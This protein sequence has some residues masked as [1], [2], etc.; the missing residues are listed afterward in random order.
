[1]V[2]SH[3]RRHRDS[4]LA[5][6]VALVLVVVERLGEAFRVLHDFLQC[7]V[8]VALAHIDRFAQDLVVRLVVL[9]RALHK[10]IVSRHAAVGN[11][12]KV[13]STT[14][15]IVQVPQRRDVEA[16]VGN[17]EPVVVPQSKPDLLVEIQREL[18]M[19]LARTNLTTS[20][21]LLQVLHW[22]IHTLAV[23][24]VRENSSEVCLLEAIRCAHQNL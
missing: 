17:R 2:D 6:E 20:V 3:L 24:D 22:A 4:F 8:A 15:R 16:V 12:Q 14:Y 18:Q 13:W 7:V 23:F 11:V 10:I 21:P 1:M 5:L 19:V 9:V